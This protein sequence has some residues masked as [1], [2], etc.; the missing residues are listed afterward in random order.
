ALV[1]EALAGRPGVPGFILYNPVYKIGGPLNTPEQRRQALIGFT[2]APFVASTFVEALLVQ[3]PI[4]S[5]IEFMVYDG[6]NADPKS[7]IYSSARGNGQQTILHQLRNFQIA[8]RTWS[9]DFRARPGFISRASYR[10][11]LTALLIG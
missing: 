10:D 11:P 4:D 9:I 1:S 5:N 8:D 7:I 6:P 2:D 3:D